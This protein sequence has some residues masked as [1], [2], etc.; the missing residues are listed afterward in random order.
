MSFQILGR[1]SHDFTQRILFN[2]SGD[3][4]VINN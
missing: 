4:K 2:Y 3:L 1:I